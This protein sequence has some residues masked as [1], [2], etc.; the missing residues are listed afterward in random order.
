MTDLVLIFIGFTGVCGWMTW[1]AWPLC[2]R[3]LLGCPMLATGM[4]PIFGLA[5]NGLLFWGMW[6]A[7][8]VDNSLTGA[9]LS[10]LLLAGLCRCCLPP[11]NP[12]RPD[13]PF[14]WRGLPAYIIPFVFW[15][16]VRSIAPDIN[17]TE[18]PMDLMMMQSLWHA[19]VFPPQDLWLAHQPVSYYY[20]GYWLLLLPSRLLDVI[21]TVAYNAGQAWWFAMLFGGAWN[22]GYS[23]LLNVRGRG[24]M[25]PGLTGL[26]A[27][28]SVAVMSNVAGF[29]TAFQRPSSGSWWWWKAS[30]A[31]HDGGTELITEFPFFSYFLGDNHPHLLAM[32][33]VLLLLAA[34]WALC[35][36]RQLPSLLDS[37]LFGCL[38]AVLIMTNTWDVPLVACCLAGCVMVAGPSFDAVMMWGFRRG[39]L[40]VLTTALVISPYLLTAQ[41]QLRGIVINH[42]LHGSL[43]EYMTIF[44]LF[45]PGVLL[46]LVLMPMLL[47][48]HYLRSGLLFALLLAAA[49]CL[50]VLLPEGMY[51][52]DVFNNRMNTVFKFYYQ[53]WMYFAL[54][55][56]MGAGLII[57]AHHHAQRMLSVGFLCL[58]L[59]GCFYPC[60]ALLDIY[61][62]RPNHFSMTLD[63]AQWIER[64]FPM[65]KEALDWLKTHTAP[66]Q[67]IA[68]APG[69]SYDARTGM[70]ASFG[71]RPMLLGWPGH[72]RQWRGKAYD[73]M[74]DGREIYLSGL[75]AQFTPPVIAV[76]PATESIDYI[77]YGP[78]ERLQYGNTDRD[79]VFSQLFPCVF[80]NQEVSIYAT[81]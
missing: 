63:G 75:Y 72:E 19:D 47:R 46:L 53:A 50:A 30:R 74:S 18:Q 38:A 81:P 9:W 54:A 79:A 23:W 37:V 27:A 4:A 42:G 12:L 76:H 3:F 26:L 15:L 17:H 10:S 66:D 21:P 45:I 20:F 69:S 49:G 56:A 36:R 25:A 44:G 32:P 8:L 59:I 43:T 48:K 71:G 22:L 80:S 64:A 52:K 28:F 70:T 40:I 39:W 13:A 33:L 51:L 55:S 5:V 11:E 65:E 41:N 60:W 77:W 31:M 16:F 6:L 61:R 67:V 14:A 35:M 73:R 68:A 78:S 58:C 57:S 2:R 24:G 62:S 34:G 29:Q 7:G 1:A